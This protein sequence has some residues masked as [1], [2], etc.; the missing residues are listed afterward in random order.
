MRDGT[1]PKGRGASF[2]TP[3]R[4]EKTH[5]EPIDIEVPYN[6]DEPQIKTSFFKDTSKSILAKNDSPDL[7]FAYSINPY[8]GCEHGCIYCYARPSH[9][10]LGFSAGLDFETKI[11]V[12]FDAPKLLEEAFQKK[13]WEPQLIV[14]SGNT[15]CYQPVERKLQLTRQ[16]LEVFLKHR[17]P[18]GLITKNALILRDIDIFQEM[19]KLNLVHITISLTSLD[20][21][22]IRKMEPRT[23]TPAERLRAIEELASNGIPVGVNAAPIIPGLTDE[24]VPAILKEAA[25]RG[26]TSAGYVLVRLPGAVKEL[27]VEWVKRE[28]PDRA[29]KILNRIREARNGELTDARFGSRMKGEGEIA[30][31]IISLFRLYARKYKLDRLWTPLSIHH[32]RRGSTGQLEIF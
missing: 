12:K 1:T 9:E 17:N 32:F 22:L 2:N 26:A 15:D 23:S 28:L 4:F 6:E 27:F 18:V 7:Q 31:S 14:F 30:D 24:E 3:N 11:M 8:R 21:E 25:A 5:L 29:G 16:C 13:T 19:A 20:P 10:Y